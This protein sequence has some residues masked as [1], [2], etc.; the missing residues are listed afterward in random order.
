MENEPNKGK[1]SPH[2]CWTI[3]ILGVLVVGLVSYILTCKV[4]CA[5]I[6]MEYISFASVIL[7]TTLS[8]FAI[9]YTY[10]SNIE[11]Q[12]QFDKINSTSDKIN[13]TSD[14]IN[15]T[16]DR[17]NST[18]DRIMLTSEKLDAN[19]SIIL[20]HL[21][22]IDNTQQKIKETLDDNTQKI[23]LEIEKI[24]NFPKQNNINM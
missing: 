15:S 9:L 16:S 1:T 3:S 18:S 19:M 17:I 5:D 11:I 7:S 24:T 10:T 20:S 22:N 13:S 14:K 23:P 12:R 8:I 2:F 6:L 21:K 4:M